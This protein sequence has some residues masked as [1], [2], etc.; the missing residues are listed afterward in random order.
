MGGV[1]LLSIG[2][3]PGE[4]GKAGVMSPPA[5]VDGLI[6]VVVRCQGGE[7]TCLYIPFLQV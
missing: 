7:K 1:L 3:E 6:G 4:E 5:V 2:E